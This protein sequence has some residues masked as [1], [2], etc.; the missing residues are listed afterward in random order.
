[1]II[2]TSAVTGSFRRFERV[3]TTLCAASLLWV[4][5]YFMVTRPPRRWPPTSSPRTCRAA[6]G[7]CPR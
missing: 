3:V 1:M 7:T 4:P 6:P 5:I 2:I